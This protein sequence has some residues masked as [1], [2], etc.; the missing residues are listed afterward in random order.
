MVG[1]IDLVLVAVGR[2]F[3]QLSKKLKVTTL[4]EVTTVEQQSGQFCRENSMV[5]DSPCKILSTL[6][7][8]QVK[9]RATGS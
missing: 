5:I 7:E 2:A 8:D 3:P 1:V 6:A 9:V 4:L